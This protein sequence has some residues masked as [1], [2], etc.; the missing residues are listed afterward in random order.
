MTTGPVPGTIGVVWY[1]AQTKNSGTQQGSGDDSADWRVFYALGTSVTSSPTFQQAEATDHVLHGANISEAGLVVGG[2]SPN[3][4]LADYF[5]V[6]FD[7]TG[8]A[9]IGYCDDHNDINGHAY[10]S[11]Q[12]SGP[13]A[14]GAA[15]PAPV[16]GSALPAP[17]NQ[18][19]PTAASVGGIPRSQVTDF[20]DDVRLGGNPELGGT[21]VVPVDDPLDILSVLYS[22]EPTS[23]TNSAPLLVAT[24]QVS[25]MTA[26]PPSSNWRMTFTAN[27]PNSVMSP[28][29]E[30]TFGISDRGDQFFVQ[31][32]TDASGAQTFVYGTAT[33]NFDGTITYTN[34]GNADSGAFDATSKRLTIKVAVSKLN[35]ALAAGHPTLGDGSILTGLR[36]STFTTAGSGASGNNKADTARG[37]TQFTINLVPPTP[38]LVV[39]RKIHGSAGPFDIILPLT[40]NAG[41]ECRTGGASGDHQVVFTFSTPVTFTS[42][43]CSGVCTV[44]STTTSGNQ[45]FVNL[46]AVANAQNI[47]VTLVGV[48]AGGVSADI[49]VPVGVLAGDTTADRSVNSADISQTKSQSGHVVTTSNFREDVTVDGSINSA[50]ISLV[51]AKSGT[52][53]P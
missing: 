23:P 48:S 25:D 7:P 20:R 28:T 1:G 29:G 26:I 31:A 10:V 35:A 14:T 53:L 46:T 22:T 8:A 27:A 6:A 45:V 36:A 5:Q 33:R 15:I 12:I 11:R 44:S 19:L 13:G 47:T 3:R 41:I 42:A 50:D 34:A 37:G 49:P 39:S 32:T 17:P 21:A 43:T 30:Y 52:A 40:G 4:N 51:K 16:E 2:M 38:T 9:V 18:P 24:M